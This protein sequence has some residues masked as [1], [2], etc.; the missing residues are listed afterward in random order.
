MKLKA[1]NYGKKLFSGAAI[2]IKERVRALA[3][4]LPA[5]MRR[6]PGAQT[7]GMFRVPTGTKLLCAWERLTGGGSNLQANA[8]LTIT[9]LIINILVII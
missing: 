6:S 1:R 3:L 2:A 5:P 7:L 8:R 4:P 9:G